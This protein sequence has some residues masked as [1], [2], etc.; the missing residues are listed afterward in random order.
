MGQKHNFLFF[1]LLPAVL[2]TA[3]S[4]LPVQSATEIYWG[5]GD[6]GELDGARFRLADFDA[7]ETG[8]VGSERGAKCIEELRLGRAATDYMRTQTQSSVITYVVLDKDRYDRLVVRLFVDG[9]AL[10]QTGLNAGHL[11]PWPHLDV[12]PVRSKPDWCRS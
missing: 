1:A 10:E 11:R 2:P 6:S 5:D 12:K 3:C 4:D 7:P 9:V 8:P